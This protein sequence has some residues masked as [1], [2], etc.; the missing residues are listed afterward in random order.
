MKKKFNIYGI[1]LIGLFLFILGACSTKQ[2]VEVGEIYTV[3]S[4]SCIGCSRC[5]EICPYHA[6]TIIDN[7]AV[8][9]PTKC[10]AC[11]KCVTVCPFDAIK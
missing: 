8:I 9:D 11:G 1:V 3:N 10:M 4:A 7:K 6:I 5:F 2:P